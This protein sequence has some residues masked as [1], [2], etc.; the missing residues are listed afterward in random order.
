[1]LGERGGIPRAEQHLTPVLQ[2]TAKCLQCLL[3][4]AAYLVVGNELAPAGER[5]PYGRATQGC[6]RTFEQLDVRTEHQLAA[7]PEQELPAARIGRRRRRLQRRL[8]LRSGSVRIQGPEGLR[9]SP[10][11]LVRGEQF[12]RDTEAVLD[13][14]VPVVDRVGDLLPCSPDF[15][16]GRMG[17]RPSDLLALPL[18]RGELALEVH[19]ERL[20]RLRCRG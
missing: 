8:S 15:A 11:K 10:A 2:L 1:M 4:A 19:R 18:G 16:L 13:L 9:E 17:V 12:R 7:R 6:E 20:D 3:R 14:L 5:S